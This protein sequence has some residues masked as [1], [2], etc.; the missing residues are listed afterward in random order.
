MLEVMAR[1]ARLRACP[2]PRDAA[3][4]LAGLHVASAPHGFRHS[5][6]THLESCRST[7]R[8]RTYLESYSCAIVK[9]NPFKMRT[10]AK[11]TSV[12]LAFGRSLPRNSFR[13]C[14]YRENNLQEPLQFKPFRMILL[15]K[16]ENNCPRITLLQKKVGGGGSGALSVPNPESPPQRGWAHGD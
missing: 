14:I 8:G 6:L 16:R 10:F 4:S 7:I 11:I 2:A 9:S 1:P 5:C 13:I 15:Y 3:S 12:P